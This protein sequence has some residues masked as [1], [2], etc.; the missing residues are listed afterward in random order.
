VCGPPTLLPAGLGEAQQ[1]GHCETGLPPVRVSH[2]LDEGIEGADVVI[3]LRLQKERQQ[4]GLLPS[5]REYARLYQV[6]TE[7]LRRAKPHAIVMHPGPMNEGIEIAADVAH[8]EHSL[9][10]EQVENGV[11]VRMA[12]L[13]LLLRGG[14][15]E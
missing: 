3:V 10:E 6:T 8:G 4:G 13:F 2:N 15:V 9:I 5:L 14:A 1:N 12:V 7:R 11:A